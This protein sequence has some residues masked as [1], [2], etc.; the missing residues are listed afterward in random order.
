VL[1]DEDMRRHGIASAVI[2]LDND[3]PWPLA[4]GPCPEAPI[5]SRTAKGF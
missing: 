2:R 3:R 1:S 5:L 4:L